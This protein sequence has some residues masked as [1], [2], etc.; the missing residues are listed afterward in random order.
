MSRP[1]GFPDL[2]GRKVGVFGVGVEGR[3]AARA[4]AAVGATVV[5]VDDQPTDGSDILDT[6]DGGIEA[7]STC[8]VVLKSP[9]IP[10]RRND[11]IELESQVHLTSALE[12]WLAGVDRA[13]VI[14]VT[15]TKGKSTTSS[16]I[17][18]FLRACGESSR[19]AGNIGS[20]P[21]DPD[22]PESEWTVLEISSFQ[23]VDIIES[24]GVVVVTSLG[25]D[26]LDWH[27]SLDQYHRDKLSLTHA[28]GHHL[29]VIPDD[30]ELVMRREHLG[31]DLVIAE[32]IDRELSNEL[33]L[34]GEHNARNVALALR[35]VAVALRIDIE[36]VRAAARREALA[37]TPLPGRL[38]M[39]HR[40]GLID[41]I[42]DGLATT[43]LATSAAMESFSERTVVAIVGGFDRGVSYQSLFDAALR[44]GAVTLVTTG[45][46]GARIASESPPALRVIRA[47]NLADAVATAVSELGGHPG[48]VLLSPAAPSFDEFTN[49]SERSAAFTAAAMRF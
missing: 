27:G 25:A 2:A 3:A 13:R 18:F 44:H 21:Y 33:G 38:T 26:H 12:V 14:G 40:T 20:P 47:E 29:T 37:F 36:T 9:G 24:P 1:R 17:D 45:P 41:F 35:V 15:G 6:N 42:D 28:E 7:L 11:V 4:L 49:W 22:A 43:P 32:G 48:V 23:A 46:A 10:R 8:D 30:P 19:V 5:L 34:V 16:L 31:G 39:V